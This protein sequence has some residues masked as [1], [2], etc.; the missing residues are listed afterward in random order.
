MNDLKGI[1]KRVIKTA[2]DMN[3][4]NIKV[5]SAFKA[6][7]GRDEYNKYVH[8]SIYKDTNKTAFD[9]A[10]YVMDN[11]KYNQL[12]AEI[13]PT[14]IAKSINLPA[15]KVREA[16]KLLVKAGVWVNWNNVV[17]ENDLQGKVL[18]R[19]KYW[20][21]FNPLKFNYTTATIFSKKCNEFYNKLT[22]NEL[23]LIT[24]KTAF[25]YRFPNTDYSDTEDVD[26]R[27]VI[28]TDEFDFD[29]NKSNENFYNNQEII[30]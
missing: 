19:S 26:L 30:V 22:N 13:I 3:K 5:T 24:D 9:I 28:N 11:L 4:H 16:V 29:S 1:I 20:Y 14:N 15:N 25:P 12:S 2:D 8:R 23:I 7:C 27:E 17:E 18:L 21:L 10:N 6:F